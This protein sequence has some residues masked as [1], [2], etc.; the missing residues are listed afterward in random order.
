MSKVKAVRKTVPGKSNSSTSSG[1]SPK[2]GAF[3]APNQILKQRAPLKDSTPVCDL[4][5][6][7]GLQRS[8]SSVYSTAD[9]GQVEELPPLSSVSE[10]KFNDLLRQ[11]L[12]QCRI[13]CNF[14]DPM[15]DLKNKSWKQG[16][17]EEIRDAISQPRFFKLFEPETFAAFF[18]MVKANLVRA[19]PPAPALATVPIVGDDITDTLYESAWPHLELVYEILKRFLESSLFDA[20]LVTEYIDQ[21]FLSRFL[22]LFNTA[23]QRERAALKMVLHRLYLKFVNKRPAIRT[24]IQ[25][26]FLTYIY[27]TRYFCGITELLDIMISIVNGYVVPLKQEHIDFLVKIILPLHT[28]YFLH[29]F[30]AS[31]AYCVMQYIQ[32]DPTLITVVVRGLVKIWPIWCSFKELLF[33]HEIGEI[34]EV[35]SITQF[36]ELCEQLFH[37]VGH[38]VRSNNFQVSE[39]AM[40]L[41]KNDRFVQYTTFHAKELFPIICP[42]LYRTGT[43]HWKPQLGIRQCR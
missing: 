40:L 9:Y 24:T 31:L 5:P 36:A 41:W 26:I 37:T 14:I 38:C 13:I 17:L 29:L 28:S 16:Y 34:V 4:L 8:V 42:Y 33:L 1:R 30:H 27:E 25:H 43:S 7:L 6:N 10:D 35:M 20:S 23:D 15:A 2:G 22:Q 32:K 3:C 19:I 18:A 12:Q 39:S 21:G 11:K